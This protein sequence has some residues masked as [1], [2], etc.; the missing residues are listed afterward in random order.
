MLQAVELC[1]FGKTSVHQ[2]D[3]RR[4]PRQDGDAKDDAKPPMNDDEGSHE[5]R[6]L[7]ENAGKYQPTQN[8]RLR[9]RETRTMASLWDWS[10]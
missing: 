5:S 1:D 7:E 6:R 2:H 10:S 3:P 9:A 4:E 8:A